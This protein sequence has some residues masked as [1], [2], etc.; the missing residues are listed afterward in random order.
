M[1]LSE[2]DHT[3]LSDYLTRLSGLKQGK[4]F[5]LD[6]PWAEVGVHPE[7]IVNLG[8][9]REEL[10]NG[11][12][13]RPDEFWDDLH[14]IVGNAKFFLG[15][16]PLKPVAIYDM[17]DCT[18]EEKALIA[19]AEDFLDIVTTFEHE[20]YD[21]KEF[22]QGAELMLEAFGTA[23]EMFSALWGGRVSGDLETGLKSDNI[24]DYLTVPSS[25]LG[26]KNNFIEGLSIWR[27]T[28]T[29]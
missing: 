20:F 19:E 9:M 4:R 13:S 11:E 5:L 7:V 1:T 21:A 14:I 3:Q 28:K 2:T 17:A 16:D 10:D 23:N 22:K 29:R 6:L 27:L 24:L 25:Y 12:Y 15:F 8:L 18:D 26:V